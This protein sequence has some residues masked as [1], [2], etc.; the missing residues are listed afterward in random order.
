MTTQEITTVTVNRSLWAE[1]IRQLR[2]NVAAMVGLSILFILSLVA[3]FAD[4]IAPHDP[5]KLDL[6]HPL[7]PPL[8][9]GHILGTDD[10]GRDV[11]SRLIYGSR[12]SLMVGFI[13]VGIAGTVGVIL[14]AISGYF[15]GKIDMIIMRVVDVLFAF[16]FLILALAFVA[17][18]GPS[19]INMMLVLG[20]VSWIG[21]ARL[22]RSVVLSLRE[23]TFVEAAHSVGASDMRILFQHILP[24]VVGIVVVQATFGVAQAILAAA[25]LSFL[26]FGVQPP[27]AEWG[28][29]LTKMRDFMRA[30]PVLVVAP[31]MMIMIT[32]LSLNFVG[33]ALRDALDPY[34]RL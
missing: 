18:L 32:V 19:L 13:V 2:R 15:G 29:M 16:P 22:V 21:Y 11:L 20:M 17:I 6:L 28:N 25:A 3:I 30:Q 5:I 27:A 9:P 12:A 33:D 10:L 26:G 7:Q 4:Q 1:T 23:M 34:M 8:T 24:N 14:G 31:G